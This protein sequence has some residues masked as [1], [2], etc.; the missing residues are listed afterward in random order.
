[1]TLTG[2]L[3]LLDLLER[4]AAVGVRLISANTDGLFI[5]VDRSDHRWKKVLR[6]WQHD[7][8]MSLEIEPLRRVAIFATN[9]YATIDA[10]GQVKRKGAGVRGAFDPG[11]VPNALV[12]ADAVVAGLLQDIPP[13]R[14]ILACDDMARFCSIRKDSD[15]LRSAVLIAEDGTE[16]ALGKLTRYYHSTTA[17]CRI[18]HRLKSDG[19]TTPAKAKGIAVLSDLPRSG[20]PADLELT[21]YVREARQVIQSMPGYRH[22]SPR[23]LQGNAAALEVFNHGLVP[24]PKRGKE[25]CTGASAKTPT[26]LWQWARYTSTGIYTGQQVATLVIDIDDPVQFSRQLNRK[27]FPLI[28]DRWTDLAGALVS[29]HGTATADQVRAG[30]ARGKLIFKF[31]GGPDHPLVKARV[32]PP[33]WRKSWGIDF[34]FEGLPTVLG[35]HP[36]GTTYHLDGALSVVP[37]WLVTEMTPKQ[38]HRTGTTASMNGDTVTSETLA[39]LSEELAALAPE[40]NNSNVGWCDKDLGGGRLIRVGRC[41]W[42][43]DGT[44]DDLSCG[45][46]KKGVPYVECKHAKCGAVRAINKTLKNNHKAPPPPPPPSPAPAPAPDAAPDPAPCATALVEEIETVEPPDDGDAGSADE[47]KQ[48]TAP[49]ERVDVEITAF[50]SVVLDQ[51]VAVLPNDP[52]LYYRGES[53]V[54]VLV[55]KEE[56]V[57]LTTRTKLRNVLGSPKIAILSEPVLGC[58]LTSVVEFYRW[59]MGKGEE[60]RVNAHPPDWL[61]GAV[62]TLKRW[63]GIRPL[64]GVAECPFP[65]ADGS[66]VEEPGYDPGTAM[67]YT[68]S[69]KFPPIPKHPTQKDAQAAWQRLMAPFGQFP[70]KS[71]EDRAAFG[72]GILTTIARPGINGPVPGV[73]VISNKAGSGKGLLIDGIGIIAQGRS[74]PTSNYPDDKEEAA[75]VKVA[76]ALSGKSIVHFDNLAEGSGYGNSALDSAITADVVDDRILGMSRNTGEITLRVSWFLSGNNVSPYKDAHRRWLVAGLLSDLEHP[77][78]RS[79]LQIPDLRQY[80]CQHRGALVVA[81]LTI[82]RAYTLAGRPTHGWAPLGS[83]ETW[84]PIVR[85]AIWFASGLDCCQ[86]RREAADDSSERQNTIAL[87]QG[88]REL[89]GGKDGG[90][91]I[92]VTRAIAMTAPDPYMEASESAYQT[93]FNALIQYGRDGR[94]AT[95]RSL[96]NHIK[97]LKNSI[98]GG[99]KFVENGKE[100]QAVLWKVV[101]ANAD[102]P[103]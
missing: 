29:C 102:T 71:A 46:N 87:L 81:A 49:P 1:V 59:K 47:P 100:H 6:T 103:T 8:E 91:G 22:R 38:Q 77:E 27:N 97:G 60:I 55:E 99:L 21:W 31:E 94:L 64:L 67:I 54:S 39:A 92:T 41:P 79:D 65:R 101:K 84:D 13:E 58:R 30:Q 73:A 96:G 34:F 42:H 62:A 2:Q 9:I 15:K 12:I 53:L 66:I 61:I 7:T 75:K 33:H 37:D 20:R 98:F 28:H 50:R 19:R 80:L 32:K 95:S 88:W 63:P 36:D 82:L 11:K 78:E 23:L 70:F 56:T 3:M 4:L 14:T 74:V 76:I 90:K 18:E 35:D 10:K 25:Q 68:P 17:G 16:T 26:L 86:T 85:G 89:P 40:L 72:A 83:F 57:A 69:M 44:A 48:P 52:S 5:Q 43:D 45:F 24:V 93:L 51:T